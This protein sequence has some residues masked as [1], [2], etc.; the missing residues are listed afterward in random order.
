MSA[1]A[2][3]LQLTEAAVPFAG[4]AIV[5]SSVIC[6]Q[7]HFPPFR[8][9]KIFQGNNGRRCARLPPACYDKLNRQ[10]WLIRSEETQMAV[11][12]RYKLAEYAHDLGAL[13]SRSKLGDN[14][15][16][17]GLTYD[18]RQ[19]TPGSLF[20]CKGSAFKPAY[21]QQAIAKG[22]VAYIT[23]GAI[24]S[25]LPH[26]IVHDVREAMPLL[27]QRYYNHPEQDISIIGITGTKG[28]S[29]TLYFLR[30]MLNLWQNDAGQPDVAFI[31]TI[32]T[33]DGVEC[34]ESHLT[35]P[36]AMELYRHLHQARSSDIRYLV[37]EVSS[38]GLKYHRL[39]GIKL[40]VAAFLN[41]AEDHISAIE[42]HDFADYFTA[43]LRIFEH[44]KRAV[45]NRD[46]PELN[47]ISAAAV[48]QDN[49]LLYYSCRD[50]L[51]DVVAAN[52]QSKGLGY[53]FDVKLPEGT[54]PFEIGMLGLF[55]IENVLAAI[56]IAYLL[57]CPLEFMQAGAFTAR[58]AGRMEVFATADRKIVALV[59]YAHNKLSFEK[60][61]ETTR[62]DFPGYKQVA[63]FGC[64]GSKGISRRQDLG[65]V[66][67]RLADY[68]YL[69]EEDPR[70][71]SVEDIS[72]EVGHYIESVNGKYEIIADRK[73]AIRTAFNAARDKTLLLILGKGDESSQMRG[74]DY[75]PVQSDVSIARELVANYDARH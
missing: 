75:V 30:E 71:E 63:I 12:E 7:C 6:C 23:E 44:S 2:A 57:G 61:F 72:R 36:E 10:P 56:S 64:P 31:S 41:I 5:L 47:T 52:V 53:S 21:L 70:Y 9:G 46:L 49:Q 4:F 18:S 15:L 54:F 39:D 35:T 45:I 66:A 67:G 74:D 32:N 19:V 62:H 24:L 37:M 42:H 40:D 34:F 25:D 68:I 38:Q 59:D 65:L 3:V 1:A 60:L 8:F 13:V 27:A 48:Q 33:Y 17:T 20:V 73:E 26:I 16:I 43:K 50:D 14:P 11:L 29:T 58:T 28:K 55:N 69:T 51:A 22:A